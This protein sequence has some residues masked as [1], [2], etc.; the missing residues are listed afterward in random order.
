MHS[1]RLHYQVVRGKAHD[2]CLSI[3]QVN[4]D[5]GRVR[6]ARNHRWLQT[7]STRGVDAQGLKI[8]KDCTRLKVARPELERYFSESRVKS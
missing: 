5:N 2:Y 6:L 4:Q 3:T 8:A 1:S 7:L